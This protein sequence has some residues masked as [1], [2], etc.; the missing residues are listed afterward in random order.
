MSKRKTLVFIF[1]AFFL[2]SL[3]TLPAA[4]VKADSNEPIT[5]SSGLTLYSP[6]N[7]TYSSNVLECNG[8]FNCPKGVPCSLNY[9]I[10]GK[11][12]GGQ[13]GL[14]WNLDVNSMRIPTYYTIDGSFQLPQ[15]PNGSHQLSIGIQEGG[16]SNRTTWVN[17]IFFT[18]SV[19]Q[20]TP[21]LT[22]TIS[23]SPTP[24]VPEFS[25]LIIPL[26]LIITMTGG[27]L[28]Y[29]KKHKLDTELFKKT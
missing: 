26:L 18:I 14:P 25:G 27:L 21:T 5:F 3:V 29:F 12:Q 13:G 28:I 8:S 4:S 19:N 11:I 15:L 10:D 16:P 2:V 24:S 23:P 9:S 20:P 7:T 6:V 1:A 17:T 22:S